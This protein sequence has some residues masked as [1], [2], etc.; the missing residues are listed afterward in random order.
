MYNGV[1]LLVNTMI[2][3]CYLFLKGC[4][5]KGFILFYAVFPAQHLFLLKKKKYFYLFTWN[6]YFRHNAILHIYVLELARTASHWRP[7]WLVVISR[8]N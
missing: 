3:E 4:E 6:E 1:E 2:S 7:T 5:K 8:S